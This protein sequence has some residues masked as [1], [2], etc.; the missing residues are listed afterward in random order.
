VKDDWPEKTESFRTKL[1]HTGWT[2]A[3]FV[4]LKNP[5]FLSFP[6]YGFFSNGTPSGSLEEVGILHITEDVREDLRGIVLIRLLI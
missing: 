1:L 6:S 2:I 5:D 4:H 3:K